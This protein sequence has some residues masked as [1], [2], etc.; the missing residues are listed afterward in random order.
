MKEVRNFLLL[1]IQ[2]LMTNKG[3]LSTWWVY[4]YRAVHEE[5]LVLTWLP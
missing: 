1:G 4:E 5:L 2:E 3:L